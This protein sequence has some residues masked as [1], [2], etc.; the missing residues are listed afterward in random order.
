MKDY[1]VYDEEYKE[2]R[3]KT[4]LKCFINPI[5]RKIQF[6]TDKPFVIAS[7]CDVSE[8]NKPVFLKYT[9]KRVKYYKGK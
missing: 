8:N 3:H 5:L 1:F 2:W 6:W 4:P 9:I 7:I